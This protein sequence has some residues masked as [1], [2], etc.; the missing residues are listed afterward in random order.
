MLISNENPSVLFAP[1]KAAFGDD[2]LFTKFCNDTKAMYGRVDKDIKG[3]GGDW[4]TKGK[5]GKGT[6]MNKAKYTLLLPPNSPMTTLTLTA[7]DVRDMRKAH[8]IEENEVTLGL[9]KSV[10]TWLLNTKKEAKEAAEK[11]ALKAS[12]KDTEEKVEQPA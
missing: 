2:E 11:A 9:P 12:K 8:L 1:F 3:D 10:T 5:I 6:V 4:Q 7:L